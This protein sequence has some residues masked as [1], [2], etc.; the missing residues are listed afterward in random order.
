M[1]DRFELAEAMAQELFGADFGCAS[2]EAEDG[3]ECSEYWGMHEGSHM[4]I[5]VDEA[6]LELW[7]LPDS[8]EKLGT[9][10]S[11]TRIL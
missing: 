5:R 3:R 8:W 7:R 11:G 6:G 1:T 10:E 9:T 2:G 4:V